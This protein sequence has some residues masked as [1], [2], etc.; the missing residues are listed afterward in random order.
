VG[1]KMEMKHLR[2]GLMRLGRRI[3]GWANG[4]THTERKRRG[5]EEKKSRRG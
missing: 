4:P 5:K 3:G 2:V 1:K